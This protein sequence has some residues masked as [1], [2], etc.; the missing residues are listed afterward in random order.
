MSPYRPGGR[1]DRRVRPGH[2]RG[3]RRRRSLRLRPAGLASL[4][5]LATPASAPASRSRVPAPFRRIAI[6]GGGDRHMEKET[7]ETPACEEIRVS[8]EASA[9]MKIW[10]FGGD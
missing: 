8:A 1:L 5:S 10:D 4:A 3:N 9:Y 6:P 7:W 2:A